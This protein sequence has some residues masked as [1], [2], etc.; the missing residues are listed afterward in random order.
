VKHAID[1]I[2]AHFAFQIVVPP[3]EQ[4]LEHQHPNDD[5]GRCPRTT[6]AATLRPPRFEGLRDDFN[7]RLVLEQRID[8]PQPVGPQ[9]VSIGQQHFEQTP[10][11]LS[12]SDHARSF[13]A[14]VRAV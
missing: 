9:F 4:M 10:L 2:G 3:V 11:A 1:Q 7:H 8:A 13:E 14:S 6:T 12:A 5:L